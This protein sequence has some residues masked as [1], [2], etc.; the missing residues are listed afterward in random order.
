MTVKEI[1]KQTCKLDPG[2]DYNIELID[3]D[4]WVFFHAS[5]SRQDWIRD[6]MCWPK[7]TNQGTYHAGYLKEFRDIEEQLLADIRN[8]FSYGNRI[9]LA[10]YSR[11]A[12]VA[13]I[14]YLE[15]FQ[16]MQGVTCVLLGLPRT[17]YEKDIIGIGS[18]VQY[19]SDLVTALPPWIPKIHPTQ[20]I[21]STN[22]GLFKSIKDHGMYVECEDEV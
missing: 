15:Y 11:G 22:T 4:L 7:S 9:I 10:G 12:A 21:P 19:G 6:F 20:V 17:V 14:A 13:L 3:G 18:I 16:W 5:W 1:I 8:E 2:R